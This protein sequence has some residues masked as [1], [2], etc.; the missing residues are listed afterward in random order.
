MTHPEFNLSFFVIWIT[1]LTL[2]GYDIYIR[3][4]KGKDATLS[5]TIY[6]WSKAYPIIP[7]AIGVLMG[8]FFWG[9]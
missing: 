5:L 1:V 8:H 6:K 9:M 7:F 2:I 4:V 3:I